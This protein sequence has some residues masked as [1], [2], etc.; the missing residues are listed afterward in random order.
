[1]ITSKARH[2]RRS[3]AVP[4]CRSP[5]RAPDVGTRNHS[6]VDHR[7]PAR[8]TAPRTVSGSGSPR[9]TV[10]IQP[11]GSFPADGSG[12]VTGTARVSTGR[13]SAASAGAARVTRAALIPGCAVRFRRA[14]P[15]PRAAISTV[16]PASPDRVAMCSHRS[17]RLPVPERTLRRAGRLARTGNACRGSSAALG[18]S[19]GHR[20][21]QRIRDAKHPPR[22]DL[23]GQ[24]T[25]K[26][27]GFR[28]A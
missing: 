14:D 23:S 15:P 4:G 5:M 20:C 8:P 2:L 9:G 19:L 3:S 13:R 10:G 27:A 25:P 21:N 26:A 24:R 1:M 22:V 28:F 7:A 17:V 6:P 16:R 11:G 12:S 18:L